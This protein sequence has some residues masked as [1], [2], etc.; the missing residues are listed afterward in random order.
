MKRSASVIVAAGLIAVF[1]AIGCGPSEA[2]L[3]KLD[4]VIAA[5]EEEYLECVGKIVS[6]EDQVRRLVHTLQKVS[7]GGLAPEVRKMLEAEQTKLKGAIPC[8]EA[9]ASKVRSQAESAGLGGGLVQGIEV[10]WAYLDEDDAWTTTPVSKPEGRY[11]K[12]FKC[13]GFTCSALNN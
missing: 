4:G 11:E 12:R 5:N 9:W 8:A 1:L 7:E 3:Q 2:D 10:V 13:N 6:A